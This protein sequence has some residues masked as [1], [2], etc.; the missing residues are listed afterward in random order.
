MRTRITR[1]RPKIEIV[2]QRT[3]ATMR[4]SDNFNGNRIGNINADSGDFV[5]IVV[6]VDVRNT[7]SLPGLVAGHLLIQE[8]GLTGENTRIEGD[9]IPGDGADWIARTRH[10]GLKATVVGS[11]P[12]QRIVWIPRRR[13]ISAGGTG[14]LNYE[15]KIG[16][17]LLVNMTDLDVVAKVRDLTNDK[18]IM[19]VR[20]S[21]MF[22][23]TRT[24]NFNAIVMSQPTISISTS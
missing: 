6:T 19:D 17:E 9:M 8:R 13:T 21:N 15:L 7:G 18:E 24:G 23:V 10:K 11:N 4:Q 22:G 2:E 20:A 1:R 5:R 14:R 3:P 12:R 16:R